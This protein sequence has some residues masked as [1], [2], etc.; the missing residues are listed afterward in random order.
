MFYDVTLEGLE[1]HRK[2]RDKHSRPYTT[3]CLI[4]TLHMDCAHDMLNFTS[5]VADS[6]LAKLAD[7]LDKTSLCVSL[8]GSRVIQ[9]RSSPQI[10]GS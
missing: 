5:I 4:A 7:K 9:G 6:G 10:L 1:C 8:A 3:E 2:R